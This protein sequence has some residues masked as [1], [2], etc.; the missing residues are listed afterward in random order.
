MNLRMRISDLFRSKKIRSTSL[1]A[2]AALSWAMG[3]DIPEAVMTDSQGTV[4]SVGWVESAH[5]ASGDL[6]KTDS[7][8][9][10]EGALG[11]INGVIELVNLV[12][13]PATILAGW[14]LSPDWTFGEIFG[15]RPIIHQ[16]WVLVSNVVYV[17]FAFLLIGMA[18]MNIF[19]HA[20]GSYAMKK[21]L[22]R[23]VTGILIVPFTW[24][25]MS[26]TLSLANLLTASVLRLPSDL[27]MQMKATDP[28]AKTELTFDVPK[29]CTINFNKLVDG[30]DK[31]KTKA[32]VGKIMEC[33]DMSKPEGK[34]TLNMK[35]VFNSDK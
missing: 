21:A 31:E 8:S 29:T 10:E 28:N 22:P 14:L 11:V 7:K 30:K 1:A 15:L 32:T 27:I 19:G 25:V 4:A 5:A 2:V 16:L 33:S 9:G 26:G 23:F 6:A 18:F 17:I 12:F 35:D 3:S 13:L 34:N 20:E 24:F